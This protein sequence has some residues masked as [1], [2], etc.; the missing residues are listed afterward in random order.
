MKKLGVLIFVF[1]FFVF[2][3][4][5]TIELGFF[6]YPSGTREYFKINEVANLGPFE[7]DFT[8]WLFIEIKDIG[9]NNP[10]SW[11]PFNLTSWGGWWDIK[12]TLHLTDTIS[13]FGMHRSVHN[14]DGLFYFHDKWHNFYGI[15]LR[16]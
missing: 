12:V 8:H 7:F 3:L 5:T 1:V 4:G 6:E 15:Q 13:I 11:A 2:V 14:F 9:T 10:F 16:W